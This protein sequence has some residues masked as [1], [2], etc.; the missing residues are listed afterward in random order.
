VTQQDFNSVPTAISVFKKLEFDRVVD[1][2]AGL[3][4]SD[5]GR[6]Q[7]RR[8]QPSSHRSTI[9]SELSMVS[10][11]K[12]MYIAD[13]SI[14]LDEFKNILPALKKTLVEN[15]VLTITELLEIAATIRISRSMKS[16]LAKR[17]AQFPLVGEFHLRLFGEKLV[18]HHINEALDERGFVKD[19]ASKELRE[20]RRSIVSASDEL[21]K[22]LESILRQISEREF[23][24]EE[25]ITTRDGRLVIPIKT[26]H[27]HR[28]PGFIHSTSASGATVFIEPAESLDLNN[29]LLELQLREQR[30]IHRILCDLTAQV[31]EIRE[32]L[33]Q[34]FSALAELDAVIARAKYSI[35]II[36]NPPEIAAEPKIKLVNARHPILLRHL[37]R[38]EVVPLTIELDQNTRTLIITGPNAGGK[39]VAMKTV[40]LLTLC[41]MSGIHIPAASDSEI[42]P[43]RDIFVD[44]GDD[45]SIENDLSTF[46][47]HLVSLRQIL[48][49]A[50]ASSL[51]LLD[52]I[53]A[54]TDPSEGGA[55]AVGT[56]QEL[57]D[58]KAIT[59]ATTHHGMLK[60]FAHETQGIGN[61]SMEFD[62]HS[63][64]PTYQ[65]K[66]GIPGSSYAFELAERLGIPRKLLEKA[67]ENVGKEKA[68]LESLLI[69]LEQQSQEY[70]TQLLDIKHEKEKLESLVA[71]YEQKTVQLKRELGTMRKKAADEAKDII[72][73]AHAKVEHLVKEI[74]ESG[75][76]TE[77]VRS[78]RQVLG[79][80]EKELQRVSN[81]EPVPASEPEPIGSG[82]VV[83]FKNGR[84][85][86]EV[87]GVQGNYA[88]VL[89]GD[90]RMRIA[91]KD[92]HKE[93][94]S[95]NK[96]MHL[97]SI[98]KSP[99][100]ANE[101]DL[102]G[103][104]GDEA[105]SQVQSFLDNAYAAGLHRVDII[106]GK[107]TGVL[108]KRVTE[109][110]KTYPHVAS[111]RLGE[112]NE[113]G[114][115]VTV[116]ELS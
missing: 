102:R 54:G 77:I 72:E 31:T 87:L 81:E 36:G 88:L 15:Q 29:A 38:E 11:A 111:F 97:T 14:P 45:Q 37:K 23:L 69:K 60:A 73:H 13:G 40:G 82:D 113:G 4:V 19:T 57:T 51:V 103:L 85:K 18:E 59:I 86:G 12:E 112:W 39:T 21:R 34:A 104:F 26:E 42:F 67:R 71:S 3:A 24:Q 1:H 98:I 68:Q 33:E 30:E 74:R 47:S 92:L 8:L 6:Q 16:Y 55:L 32:P 58:R 7:V 35:A 46:S 62:Q 48:E 101:I 80:L 66:S 61:A 110:L 64:T 89:S 116:A 22:R 76:K 5:P 109:F 2:I 43:F 107:G 27:K 20:I 94:V 93:S 99:D 25:I 90:V 49:N 106:H 56:L 91:L 114:E 53:G 28:I 105:I 65:F 17:A 50:G 84:E 10:E 115:G 52:E 100:A 44:I 70:R 75:A 9:E 79:Q 95:S 63:L 41:A 78:S 83:R 108:R 96:S